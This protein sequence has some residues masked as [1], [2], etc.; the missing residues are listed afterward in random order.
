MNYFKECKFSAE[1]PDMAFEKTTIQIQGHGNNTTLA[2][3]LNKVRGYWLGVK[4]DTFYD[5]INGYWLGVKPD[6]LL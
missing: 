4:P 1:L 3:H 2:T 6:T 5:V